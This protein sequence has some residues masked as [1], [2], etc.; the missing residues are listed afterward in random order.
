MNLEPS[1]MCTIRTASNSIN[2]AHSAR[3]DGAL[4]AR[5]YRFPMQREMCT[6]CE[7]PS[8]GRGLVT[9]EDIDLTRNDQLIHRD[10]AKAINSVRH[11]AGAAKARLLGRKG[12]TS[13]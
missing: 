6:R 1:R 2:R 9:T 10:V 3:K 8:Y 11:A 7:L 4:N 12:Q 13:G 5:G